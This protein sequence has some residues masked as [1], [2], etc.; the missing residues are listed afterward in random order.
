MAASGESGRRRLPTLSAALRPLRSVPANEAFLESRHCIREC[1]RPYER[2]R[3]VA[4]GADG[5]IRPC[6]S[7]PDNRLGPRAGDFGAK[8]LSLARSQI[9]SRPSPS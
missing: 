1:L 9:T 5:D 6:Y 2:K 7:T 8:L 4:M 3:Q